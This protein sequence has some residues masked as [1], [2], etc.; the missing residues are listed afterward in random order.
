MPLDVYELASPG[1]EQTTITG[2]LVYGYERVNK[3]TSTMRFSHV[4]FIYHHHHNPV[5]IY[6]YIM[7]FNTYHADVCVVVITIFDLVNDTAP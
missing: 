3:T 6:I 2:A 4:Q 1:P 7:F 5:N